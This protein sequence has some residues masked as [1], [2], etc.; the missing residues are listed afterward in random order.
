MLF[1]LIWRTLH[2]LHKDISLNFMVAG[3][4]KFSPD[5]CFGLL[6]QKYRRTPVSS[7]EDIARLTIQSTASGL[8]L[9]QLVGSESQEVFVPSYN[10][11]TF[12]GGVLQATHWNQESAALPVSF[13]HCLFFPI[14]SLYF[15]VR[16]KLHND[17]KKWRLYCIFLVFSPPP[18]PHKKNNKK[19]KKISFLNKLKNKNNYCFILHSQ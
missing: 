4:T 18:P 15:T 10:W 9:A 3:H 6:K 7:L 13:L 1:Y 17:T 5:W 14:L 8:N 19:N 2:G 11:Q 16:K 12:L